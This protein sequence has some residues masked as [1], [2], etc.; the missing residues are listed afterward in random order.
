MNAAAARKRAAVRSSCSAKTRRPIID[1]FDRQRCQRFEPGIGV[2][3]WRTMT[4]HKSGS[5]RTPS[6]S[7]ERRRLG[8]HDQ[9]ELTVAAEGELVSLTVAIVGRAYDRAPTE[10]LKLSIKPSRVDH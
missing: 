7:S 3:Y 4:E 2:K 8:A 6:C 1:R 10:K 5:L 9:L